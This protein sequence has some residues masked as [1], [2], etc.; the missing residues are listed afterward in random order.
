MSVNKRMS[1]IYRILF[2]VQYEM[3][4]VFSESTFHSLSLLQSCDIN[5]AIALVR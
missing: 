3:F 2:L 5:I 1:K 4:Q